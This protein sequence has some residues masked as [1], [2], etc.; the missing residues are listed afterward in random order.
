MFKINNKDTRRTPVTHIETIPLICSANQWT[1]F[2]M[3]VTWRRSRVLIVNFEHI[4]HLFLVFL[5]L[6][7]NTSRAILHQFLRFIS[8]L[9]IIH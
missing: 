7:L 6:T 2:S 3:I 4:S 1:G 9:L 5:F 8:L